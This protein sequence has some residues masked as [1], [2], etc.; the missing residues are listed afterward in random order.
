MFLLRVRY[1][2]ETQLHKT[3][4]QKG[5]KKLV[6]NTKKKERKKTKCASIKQRKARKKYIVDKFASNIYQ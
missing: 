5:K 3:H 4:T 6:N 1:T 2:H